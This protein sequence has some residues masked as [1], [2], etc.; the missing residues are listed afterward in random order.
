MGFVAQG[1]GEA[2]HFGVLRHGGYVE[3]CVGHVAAREKIANT[4]RRGGPAAAK[5]AHSIERRARGG[6]PIVEQIV[7]RRIKLRLRRIPRLQQIILDLHFVDGSDRGIGIGVRGEQHALR[8]RIQL[9]RFGE[10]GHAGH[11]GHAL[12][13]EEE[14]DGFVALQQRVADFERGGAGIGANDAVM[15]RVMLTQVALD[16]A[17]DFRIVVN[18]EQNGLRHRRFLS[19]SPW[20]TR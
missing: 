12:I 3:K 20:Y 10:E 7:E 2:L 17:Q 8:F 15:L 11:L 6:L 5:H 9:H 13:D 18:S 19:E 4:E 14:R 1:F 16:G